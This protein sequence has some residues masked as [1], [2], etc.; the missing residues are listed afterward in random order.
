MGKHDKLSYETIS[1]LVPPGSALEMMRE[2]EMGMRFG[3]I[4]IPTA[5]EIEESRKSM[6][7]LLGFDKVFVVE[8]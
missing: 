6:P 7:E 1:K 3:I 2:I 8:E 5:E 4:P